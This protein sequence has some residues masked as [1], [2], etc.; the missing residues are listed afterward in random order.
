MKFISSIVYLYPFKEAEHYK[1]YDFINMFHKEVNKLFTKDTV[2][3][4]VLIEKYK[5]EAEKYVVQLL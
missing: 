1:I 2:R 3:F 5:R 4:F